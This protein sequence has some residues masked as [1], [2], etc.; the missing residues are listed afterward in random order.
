VRRGYAGEAGAQIHYAACGE[1]PAVILLHQTPRSWDEY[2]EVLPVLAAA[3]LGALAPDTV[4]MGGSDPAPG[5]DTIEAYA[6]GVLRFADLM[7]IERFSLVG[8]HTG[9]VIAVEVA[10]QE[11]RR[12]ER[13]VL[14]STALVDAANRERRR[15]RAGPGVDE[16]VVRD[17][18]G[19]LLE[20]WQGRA[21]FYPE[22]RP[23]LLQRFVADALRVADPHAGH[24]AVGRYEM[25]RR[26]PLIDAPTL[27]IG[28][29]RDPH[30]FPAFEPLAAALRA[31][32]SLIEDGMVPLE[33][34]AATFAALVAGFLR[35]P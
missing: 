2:R 31:E 35:R 7:G 10:A 26:L 25:E 32:R 20:L 12:V 29:R 1:G 27:V 21:G 17:D 33:F 5:G 18:G 19:H 8:H 4:G 6:A 24:L 23:D 22:G 30:A 28:H 3:G 16:V 11:P 13:L 9:G 34:T 14:S 15:A